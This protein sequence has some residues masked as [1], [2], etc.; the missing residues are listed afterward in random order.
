MHPQSQRTGRKQYYN[1]GYKQTSS[2]TGYKKTSSYNSYKKTSR[3]QD[4]SIQSISPTSVYKDAN[5]CYETFYER[6]YPRKA[7]GFFQDIADKIGN[8]IDRKRQKLTGKKSSPPIVRKKVVRKTG[9]PVPTIQGPVLCVPFTNQMT[10]EQRNTFLPIMEVLLRVMSTSTPAPEDINTL[11][12]LTRDLTRDGDIPTDEFGNS[13]PGF[14]GFNELGI[15]L[16]DGGLLEDGDIIVDVDGVPHIN[17]QF[18]SFPL[19]EVSLLTDEERERFLP[20]IRTFTSVLKKDLIDHEEIKL[21]VRQSE[22]LQKFVPEEWK[23]LI[24]ASLE[25]TF[26]KNNYECDRAPVISV[27]APFMEV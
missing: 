8:L 17:T 2:Y 6:V 10:L 15:E 9:L 11:L 27:L 26:G 12:V 21:L 7:R 16:D 22:E 3:H 13:I 14:A 25:S 4:T 24:C 19:S 5:F 18:G 20:V 1:N 23:D